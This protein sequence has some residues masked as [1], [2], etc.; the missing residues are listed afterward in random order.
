MLY[1][2]AAASGLR[3]NELRSLRPD[4][5]M[6]AGETPAVTVQAGYSKRGKRSGRDDV[7]PIPQAMAAELLEWHKGKPKGRA[8]LRQKTSRRGKKQ[9]TVAGGH[10]MLVM[11]YQMPHDGV[12]YQELGPD[13]PNKIE[14]QRPPHYL[15][16]RLESPGHQV[17]LR[18]LEQAA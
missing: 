6:L 3:S 2:L 15:V 17:I 13:Y 16:K 5:F 4:S 9:I 10:T 18:P 12:D 1:K 11:M 8:V 7:Q 14:S